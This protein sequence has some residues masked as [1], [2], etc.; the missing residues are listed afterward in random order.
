MRRAQ[1]PGRHRQP[2]GGMG[3]LGWGRAAPAGTSSHLV[4]WGHSLA[5][6][7]GHPKAVCAAPRCTAVLSLCVAVPTRPGHLTVTAVTQGRQR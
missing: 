5:A 3:G 2:G 6:T 7:L 1:S 4:G